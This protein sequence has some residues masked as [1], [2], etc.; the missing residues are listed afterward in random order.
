MIGY[1]SQLM[2]SSATFSEFCSGGDPSFPDPDKLTMTS[3]HAAITSAFPLQEVMDL[4]NKMSLT[5]WVPD[6]SSQWQEEGAVEGS[7]YL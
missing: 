5:V 7:Y 6:P 1:A 2:Q 3:L 4:G